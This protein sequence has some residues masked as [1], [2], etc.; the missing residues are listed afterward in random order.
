MCGGVINSLSLLIE[1]KRPE[2]EMVTDGAG[3]SFQRFTDELIESEPT[4]GFF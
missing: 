2:G 3:T 1:D 4:V